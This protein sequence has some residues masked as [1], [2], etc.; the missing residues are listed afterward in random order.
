M[1]ELRLR[2]A[3]S[4]GDVA[5]A[6]W[7]ACANPAS[8]EQGNGAGGAE[9]GPSC[10]QDTFSRPYYNPFISHDFLSSL[11][12]SQ[13]VRARVGWQPM[14]LL[15]EDAAGALVG[16]VPCY[17]KSH[18]RGEY[19]FDHG[20]AEAYERAGGSYYPKLQVA[21]PF[22][23]ATGRRLLARPGP[24]AEA[25][26]LA[27]ADALVDI[28]RRSHASSVHVNFSTE[29]EWD[30]LGS[31]GF[32]KRTHQQFHW[33]NAGYD[34]FDAFLGAL[35]SRK[36]KTIRRER[37]DALAAGI[38]V[39]WLTGADLT[40]SVWDAFFDFYME[41]GSRKWGR[42]YLTRQFYS[43]VGE[44]MAD[45]ILL[46]MA[47][48][49]G[50]FIAGAINFIGSDTL[51]GRHWGAIEHHPFLHFELCYYQAIQYAIAHKLVRVEAGA[52]GEHKI[53]RGY[54]PTTTYSAHY[55]VDA[56][57]RRAIEDFLR[58]ERAYVAAAEEELAE[59]AP[60][61]KV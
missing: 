58:R 22:T 24:Q 38:S 36:R 40:E 15:A 52:Q 19:V 60:F 45:R 42:P 44:K 23:P 20:W 25:V 21:V 27:L 17:V 28:C 4:I 3:N 8:L 39:H 54:V 59:A 30:V 56:G 61:R 43:L 14:H 57:L 1:I 2:V 16:A 13:S 49:N 7:D 34:S 12:L 48:R 53:S 11:E 26:R 46:V 29:A 41:T 6:S 5:A 55:I 10:S 51:F 9:R 37:A 33:E 50:R 35:A 32:L 18:S 31:R 47:K